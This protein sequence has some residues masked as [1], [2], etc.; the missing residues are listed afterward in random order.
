MA[1]YAF[2]DENYIVTEV[3]TGKDESNFDWER[4][5]GDLRGQLCRRTSYNTV[6]GQHLT[7]GTS[8]RKNYA[9]IGY[10][11]DPVRDA[12]IAP[13]PYPSWILDE[14]TCFWQPPVLLPVEEGKQFVWNESTTSWDLLTNIEAGNI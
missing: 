6:G 11:Y 1:H 9:G 3:I 5:Y 4:Y 12:F 10:T 7:G 14:E 2:L 8:F 13:R